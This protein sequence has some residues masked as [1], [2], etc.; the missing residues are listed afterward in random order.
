M[1]GDRNRFGVLK[2]L[3][4]LWVFFGV[5]LGVGLWLTP[6][7]T[8][9]LDRDV[10][11][12]YSLDWLESGILYAWLHLFVFIP[13]FALSFDQKVSY[14]SHWRHLFPA[15]FYVAVP[16][17]IWDAF[18]TLHGIW[19]FNEMY[20]SGV[21]L[22]GLPAEEWLFFITV[23]FACVFI[24]DCLNAYFPVN[25]L[26]Y[27]EHSVTVLLLLILM[28][29]GLFHMGQIYS[30]SASLIAVLSL[31]WVKKRGEIDFLARFYRA[32]LVV[33]IPFILTDGLLT[34]GF[35]ME[36]IVLYNPE[37]F[38]G[39]RLVSIPVEDFIYGFALLLQV[40]YLYVLFRRSSR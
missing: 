26:I 14:F 7:G 18:F 28:V 16:F 38:S 19:G 20:L 34:G 13:V 35:T 17:I 23:P 21:S 9:S 1:K 10:S 36:P 32:F 33:L 11:V 8:P 25:K 12:F 3:F 39:W 15:I 29:F 30:W 2:P 40:N 4:A 27:R 24:Y 22:L 6:E 31:L 37:N 5:C